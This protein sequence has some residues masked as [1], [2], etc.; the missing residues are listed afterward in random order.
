MARMARVVVP[1]LWHH[2][3][4][5]V[6]RRETIFFDDQGRSLGL[7]LFAHHSRRCPVRDGGLLSGAALR[8][9]NVSQIPQRI[10]GVG[11][12]DA[13]RGGAPNSACPSL[14]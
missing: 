13:G 8:R 7:Q 6:N 1:G 2:V 14:C 5:R 9:G 10:V 4:Q 12:G 11:G 3:T